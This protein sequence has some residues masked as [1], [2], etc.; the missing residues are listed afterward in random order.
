MVNMLKVV[1]ALCVLLI[2]IGFALLGKRLLRAYIFKSAKTQGTESFWIEACA[3]IIVLVVAVSDYINN[4]PQ[5]SIAMVLG[6]LIFA[7]GWILQFVARKQLCDD[8]TFESRLSSG[9]EAAQTKLYAYI[10][11]PGASALI[12]ILL[13]L[14]LAL[15]SYWAFGVTVV[16]FVPSVL[17]KI[18]QEERTLYDKFGDRWLEYKSGSKRII[19]GVF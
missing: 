17:F 14:S 19:P 15:G 16:L 11:Y 7:S 18:S 6:I 1:I 5:F 3:G 12:L 8:K 2:I 13:G 9:F 10:R 4:N